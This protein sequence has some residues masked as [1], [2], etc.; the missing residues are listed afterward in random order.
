MDRNT[1]I[2]FVLLA[3]LLFLYL[4]L[5][6][7]GSQ[8]V[9]AQK[10]AYEDSVARVKAKEDS[11]RHKKDS[12]IYGAAPIDSNTKGFQK[13]LYGPE[14]VATLENNLV[15]VA[16]SSKGGQ[17]KSVTLKKYTSYKNG[18]VVL[19]NTAFDRLSYT[20][21]TENNSPA[22]TADLNFQLV[23]VQKMRTAASQLLFV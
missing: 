3:V 9:Q 1:V 22:Q 21:N 19:L 6:T 2:G 8:D 23:G 13:A 4:F 12:V 11:I 17:P 20:I 5:S 15:K 14:E 7:K 18:P 10:Q 16:F